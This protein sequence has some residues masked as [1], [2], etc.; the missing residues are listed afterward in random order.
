MKI[1]YILLATILVLSGC[2]REDTT[3]Q[4]MSQEII[5]YAKISVSTVTST[6]QTTTTQPLCPRGQYTVTITCEQCINSTGPCTSYC[7]KCVDILPKPTTTMTYQPTTTSTIQTTT[8]VKTTTSTTIKARYISNI[9]PSRFNLSTNM[10]SCSKDRDCMIVPDCCGWDYGFKYA[11]NEW[12][13]TEY[14]IYKKNFCSSKDH[15]KGCGW[16]TPK[17]TQTKCEN[18]K[19]ILSYGGFIPDNLQD[20][21]FTYTFDWMHRLDNTNYTILNSSDYISYEPNETYDPY[22]LYTPSNGSKKGNMQ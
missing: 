17:T 6:I 21:N 12:S 5:D 4:P 19:C 11:I 15:R 2:L 18:G 3:P 13:G 16:S 22:G 7:Y 10:T 14:S 20:D 8:T 1:T 9:M